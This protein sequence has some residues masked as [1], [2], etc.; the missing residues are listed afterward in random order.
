MLLFF[1]N[2]RKLLFFCCLFFLTK[3]VT[4]LPLLF[5]LILSCRS[6]VRGPRDTGPERSRSTECWRHQISYKPRGHSSTCLWPHLAT[7]PQLTWWGGAGRYLALSH[8]VFRCISAFVHKLPGYSTT[9]RCRMD[10]LC[11]TAREIIRMDPKCVFSRS[12]ATRSWWTRGSELL[13]E[14]IS[15]Q[16]STAK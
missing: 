16:T 1:L 8:C 5:F 2:T 15:H 14:R 9:R 11:H 10:V 12:L 4:F 6:P 7:S 13:D 3:V